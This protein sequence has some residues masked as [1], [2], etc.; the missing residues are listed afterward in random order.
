[1]HADHL[2]DRVIQRAAGL[3]GVRR[4][5]LGSGLGQILWK[6]LGL[7]LSPDVCAGC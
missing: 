6:A 1:M 2:P 5:G 3:R 7:M 4:R